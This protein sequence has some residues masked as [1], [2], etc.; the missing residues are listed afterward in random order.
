LIAAGSRS[1]K[2]KARHVLALQHRK[3]VRKRV[4]QTVVAGEQNGARRKRLAFLDRGPEVL[5]VIW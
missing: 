5:R 2:K 3:H 4:N 1:Y